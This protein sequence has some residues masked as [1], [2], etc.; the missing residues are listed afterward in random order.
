[1]LLANRDHY[2]YQKKSPRYEHATY[3][4]ATSKE[5]GKKKEERGKVGVVLGFEEVAALP[6]RISLTHLPPKISLS[7]FNYLSQ[8]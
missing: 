4:F 7:P 1:M 8:L 2:R 3:F 6:K 5:Q